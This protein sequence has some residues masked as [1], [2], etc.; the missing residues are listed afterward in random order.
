MAEEYTVSEFQFH[1]TVHYTVVAR[2][3]K[4]FEQDSILNKASKVYRWYF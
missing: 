3:R 2:I 1:Y 4:N